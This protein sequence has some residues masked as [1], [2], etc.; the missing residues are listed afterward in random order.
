M[1]KITYGGAVATG[2]DIG[3]LHATK[4]QR[5]GKARSPASH[6]TLGRSGRPST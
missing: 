4:S 1:V 6:L 2:A 3:G 5:A